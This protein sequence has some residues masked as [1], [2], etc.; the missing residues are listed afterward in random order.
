MTFTQMN[1]PNEISRPMIAFIKK[2]HPQIK[3]V[4]LLNPNDATGQETEQIARKAW[5]AA[6]VKV[7]E[8]DWYERGSTEFQPVAAKL[9]ATK[10]DA[11]DLCSSPPADA[12][13]V[14]KE[15]SGLGW[16][17]VKVVE[18]GTGADGL[19]ATGGKTVEG[20]YLGAAVSFGEGSGTP[21]Q[22]ELNE[23]VRKVSGD[24]INAIQIGFYDAPY[25]LKAAMEKAQSVDPVEVAKVMPAITFDSFYG[26]SSFGGKETYGSPQQM[27]LP[28]I[29][30]QLK[31]GKLVEVGRIAPAELAQRGAR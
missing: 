4:A 5:E 3:T 16:N 28:V 7:V 15:L 20:A 31:D 10:A 23:G 29:V 13:L 12:G 22:R 27:L 8:S 17:G 30:T 2:A 21:H 1:T 6:G 25:A 11:V 26:K 24:S 18:V 14:F 19:L 9:S